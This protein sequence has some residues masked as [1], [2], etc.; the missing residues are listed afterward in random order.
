MVE[1][2]TD[3]GSWLTRRQEPGRI[4]GQGATSL[5]KSL[6]SPRLTGSN[7]AGYDVHHPRS[8]S[9]TTWVSGPPII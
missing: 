8:S 4:P 2:W 5:R 7:R 6:A 9:P 1:D 3:N